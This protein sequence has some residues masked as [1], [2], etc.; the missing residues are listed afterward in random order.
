VRFV[1]ESIGPAGKYELTVVDS[2]G[3]ELWRAET[4]DTFLTLPP[5]VSLPRNTQLF[6]YVD[7][8]G[9]DAR[10]RTTRAVSL[11]LVP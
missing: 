8:L 1:W 10:A 4:V 2:L 7:A 9:P 5:D 3:S 11:R 6:W